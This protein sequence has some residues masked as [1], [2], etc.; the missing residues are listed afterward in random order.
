MGKYAIKRESKYERIILPP[1]FAEI[2]SLYDYDLKVNKKFKEQINEF[3]RVL[4]TKL[5]HAQTALIDQNLS[6]LTIKDYTIIRR[7]FGFCYFVWMIE[8]SFISSKNQINLYKNEKNVLFH[9]LF[10]V[11]S[12][13][14][15]DN[16]ILT[17]FFQGS[18]DSDETIGMALNEGYTQVLL[19]RYFIDEEE[20]YEYET[21]VASIIEKIVGQKETE[22]AYFSADLYNLVK[23]V[24]KYESNHSFVSFL[25]VF[26]EI[27]FN[28]KVRRYTNLIDDIIGVNRYLFNLYDQKL[29]SDL[30]Q[31]KITSADYFEL[32]NQMKENIKQM[33]DKMSSLI[34]ELAND[35]YASKRLF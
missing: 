6:S 33:E 12:T 35:Y 15:Y 21:F 25:E 9:E 13:I 26:D 2:K 11:C 16:F 1:D 19:E 17:G 10:H 4:Y 18:N 3:R 20:S 34:E 5:P 27:S 24:E 22:K 7:L 29:K 23:M 30:A 28:L 32:L 31:N 8:A 14:K